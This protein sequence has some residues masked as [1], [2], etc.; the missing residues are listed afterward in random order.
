MEEE[1]S[2]T[3][4]EKKRGIDVVDGKKDCGKLEGMKS[5]RMGR[6]RIMVG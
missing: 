2:K 3:V 1:K 6:N 5:L 4:K